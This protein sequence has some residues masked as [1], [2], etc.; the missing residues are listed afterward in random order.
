MLP[1]CTADWTIPRKQ[2]MQNCRRNAA[3]VPAADACNPADTM[4]HWLQQP[5]HA[6]LQTSC[7]I[8]C[9][10][11]PAKCR[12]SELLNA[13]SILK[14][15]QQELGAGPGLMTH[16]DSKWSNKEESQTVLLTKLGRCSSTLDV[17]L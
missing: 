16:V 12:Y 6:T 5:M 8:G 9:S 14:L 7:S 1:A 17:Y 11:A 15:S 10:S 3:L 13:K 2:C 4:Q